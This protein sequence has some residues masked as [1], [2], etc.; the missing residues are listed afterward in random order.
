[1]SVSRALIFLV[2]V[3]SIMLFA[4]VIIRHRT[5]R[6]AAE[7]NSGIANGIRFLPLGDSYTIGQ[8]VTENNRWPNQLASASSAK[9]LQIVANPSVTGYTSQDL[10]DHELPL[11]KQLK[12]DFV[13]VQIGVNDYV[14]GV[15]VA[16]FQK[17]LEYIVHTLQQELRLPQNI[18]L[19]TIPDYG[20][21][22]TGAQFGDPAA[23]EAGVKNANRI[24]QKVADA[25]KLAVADIFPV[26]QGVS[27][28]PGLVASDGLHPS[29]KQYSAWTEVILQA[30]Q[31]NQ[32]PRSR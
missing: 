29:A 13:T 31:S 25:S 2:V 8:S 23:S 22:P 27:A 12:P 4:V 9:K 24:I 20:Q 32:L 26:S 1:M 7:S 6:S 10:I 18:L 19:V 5:D 14:Q 15:P 28:D 30:M 21:T 3:V 17:N 16:T 11:I